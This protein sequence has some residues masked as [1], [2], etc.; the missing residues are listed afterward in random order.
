VAGGRVLV[1]PDEARTD[2][3]VLADS[4]SANG[5]VVLHAAPT[6]LRTVLEAARPALADRTILSGHERLPGGLARQL[7]AAGAAVQ[8]GFLTPAGYVSLGPADGDGTWATEGTPLFGI[9]IGTGTGI[10]VLGELSV[11]GIRTGEFARWLPDGAIAVLGEDPE[12]ALTET[13]FAGL[14]DVDAVAAVATA[15]GGGPRRGRVRR[16][17]ETR[18]HGGVARHARTATAVPVTPVVLAALPV[19]LGG[20][21]D[22]AALARLAADAVA[23]T[24]GTPADAESDELVATL[25]AP[26]ANCSTGGTCRGRELLPQ[27]RQLAPRCAAGRAGQSGHRDA[28]VARGPVRRSD[29]ARPRRA[30]ARGHVG[31]GRRL[32]G[33]RTE[34]RA[35][36]QDEEVRRDHGHLSAARHRPGD[37]ADPRRKG[38]GRHHRAVPGRPR[39]AAARLA[40][41][42]RGGAR[43]VG[44]PPVQLRKTLRRFT[45]DPGPDG[46]L[47]CATCR[48][49]RTSCRTRPTRRVRCSARR[50]YL[51]RRRYSPRCNSRADLLP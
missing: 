5:I 35:H 51:R 17:E 20:V 42:A 24:R 12:L 7:T 13:A 19:T 25:Y 30:D 38:R 45:S 50:P 18:C 40:A 46:V 1:A 11:D 44:R 39:A 32:T 34:Y 23:D 33:H 14:A 41:L 22:R 29:A 2:G 3:A 31:R 8:H 10:G 47:L 4:L 48:S 16:V 15:G 43:A 21:V 26:G 49:R 28:G 27:R 9:T 6:V 36:Q 37:Q